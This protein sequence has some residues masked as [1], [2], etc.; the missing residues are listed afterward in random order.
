M[1]EYIMNTPRRIGPLMWSFLLTAA[2]TQSVSAGAEPNEISSALKPF[3]DRHELA[4]A[5]TLVAS[6]DAILSLDAIGYADIAKNR[7]MQTDALFWIAS[8]GKPIA[9]TALMMLVDEGKVHLDDPVTKYLPKFSP[10]IMV[11]TT[12]AKA[13]SLQR[14]R[15]AIT[16]RNLLSHSSGLPFSSPPESPTLDLLPLGV[17]VQS[18][19]LLPLLFEPGADYSYSNAGINTAARVIEV[20]SGTSYEDFVQRRLFDPLKM[21]DTTFWPTESQLARLATSYKANAAGTD[22]EVT[23]ITQLHYPLTDRAQRFSV[24]AGGLFST[25]SDLAKFC[26]MILNDGVIGGRRYVSAAAI[27]EMSHNQLAAD[28]VNR[29]FRTN[30]QNGYGLGW[31]TDSSG[32]FGHSGAYATNMSIDQ[33]HGVA[34][35][36]LVQHASFPGNGSKA[37]LAFERAAAKQ[38]EPDTDQ[39]SAQ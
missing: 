39:A 36:W 12:G 15:H 25:A 14:P 18:Y 23:P 21:T 6:K 33:K 38:F 22:L 11:V 4:G 16:I 9:A 37:R 24:A 29:R 31:T 19:A 17:R 5:V 13:V 32:A 26:Q 8:M 27:R 10:Q 35:V 20:V 7:S 34:L 28:V 30:E 2:L 3:V 1:K